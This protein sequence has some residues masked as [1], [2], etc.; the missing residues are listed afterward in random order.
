ML[1]VSVLWVGFAAS[2]PASGMA[3]VFMDG[4]GGHR[5][6]PH[7]DK[8]KTVNLTNKT[9][10]GYYDHSDWDLSGI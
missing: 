10:D 3:H 9:V 1:L 8:C 2:L 4:R 6:E 7:P 5:A